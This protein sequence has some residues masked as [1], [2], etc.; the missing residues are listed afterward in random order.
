[1]VSEK[2]TITQSPLIVS[3]Q[4]L[5]T[6]SP[7]VSVYPSLLNLMPSF[8]NLNNW[9]FKQ[10]MGLKKKLNS[11][12]QNKN[13]NKVIYFEKVKSVNWRFKNNKSVKWQ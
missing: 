11:K 12:S 9:S 2:L 8:I 6:W 1:M 10:V 3:D 13:K 5:P 7:T 4:V